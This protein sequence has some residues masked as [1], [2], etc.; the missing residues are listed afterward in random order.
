MQNKN[1]SFLPLK[2]NWV[3]K[4]PLIAA[5]MTV[6]L[7]VILLAV[8][9]I[10]NVLCDEADGL[11]CSFFGFYIGRVITFAALVFVMVILLKCW[12]VNSSFM[13]ILISLPIAVFVM[14]VVM[15]LGMDYATPDF[16]YTL[17]D[18]GLFLPASF[19]VFSIMTALITIVI[20]NIYKASRTAG[21]VTCILLMPLIFASID[22]TANYFLSAHDAQE[23]TEA[24]KELTFQ[25]YEPSYAPP[26]YV[27]PT[28]NLFS[29]ASPGLDSGMFYYME[30]NEREL[31]Q[32]PYYYFNYIYINTAADA[33]N[34][35]KLDDYQIIEYEFTSDYNPPSDCGRVVTIID[36]AGRSTRSDDPYG[37]RARPCQLVGRADSGCDVYYEEH[38]G[39]LSSIDTMRS[40]GFCKIDSTVIVI[41]PNGKFSRG[42]NATERKA[43]MIKIF[44]SLKPLSAQQLKDYA[45]EKSANEK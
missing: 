26:G 39:P 18:Y 41:V 24:I 22:Y 28:A 27:I 21:V 5:V 1:Q 20:S 23:Q 33:D 4:V 40:F 36:T 17:Q 9:N 16:P 3:R 29:H 2:H 8:P 37:D 25:V 13:A 7:S 45:V 43:E 19:I 14:S 31:Y 34:D 11:S 42:Q 10:I 15:A 12:V 38:V 6:F 32:P 35:E 30:P 44:N